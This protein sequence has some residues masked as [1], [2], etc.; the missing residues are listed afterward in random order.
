MEK[1]E[2]NLPLLV[3]GSSGTISWNVKVTD[4]GIQE[5]SAD[6]TGY[7]VDENDVSMITQTFRLNVMAS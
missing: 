4:T 6:L 1:S 3:P 5:F 7:P 2:N